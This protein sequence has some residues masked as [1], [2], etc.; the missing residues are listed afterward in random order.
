[1]TITVRVITPDKIVLDSVVE[2]IILPSA[3]GQLGIL[4]G[5]APLLTALNTGVVRLRS[6]KDWQNIAVLGGFAEVDENEVKV[7]VN[8]AELGKNINKET[9]QSEYNQAQ[10]RLDEATKGGD[11]LKIVKAEQSWKKYRARLQA[12]GGLTS[13]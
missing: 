11:R 10:I 1:M 9:A 12:A 6:G 5:H 2:E 13:V 4:T 7:L 3:T 8:G